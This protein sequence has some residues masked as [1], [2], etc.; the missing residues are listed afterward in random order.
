MKVERT[1]GE[2][3]R[4]GIHITELFIDDFEGLVKLFRNS[5]I[6]QFEALAVSLREQAEPYTVEV[7]RNHP[8]TEVFYY[9]HYDLEEAREFARETAKMFGVEQVLIWSWFGEVVDTFRGRKTKC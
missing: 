1:L 8:Y 2:D 5:G 3:G 9:A 4:I 7:Q 6:P